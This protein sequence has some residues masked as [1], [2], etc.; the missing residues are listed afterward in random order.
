MFSIRH[1]ATPVKLNVFTYALGN[2]NCQCRIITLVCNNIF[3]ILTVEI[4]KLCPLWFV[5]EEYPPWSIWLALVIHSH[6]DAGRYER[7]RGLILFSNLDKTAPFRRSSSQQVL[8]DFSTRHKAGSCGKIVNR[9]GHSRGAALAAVFLDNSS[10]LREERK[11]NHSD[12][13]PS[14]FLFGAFNEKYHD[15]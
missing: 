10:S 4:S 15:N 6:R 11:K 3:L 13:F 1:F 5:L 14:F 12:F 8:E 7:R 2:L 9:G